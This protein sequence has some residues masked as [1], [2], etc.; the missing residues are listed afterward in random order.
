MFSN[1]GSKFSNFEILRLMTAFEKKLF[2]SIVASSSFVIW[3]I[4]SAADF[5][6][7]ETFKK[8]LADCN[9]LEFCN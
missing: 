3:V 8:L 2:S 5:R 9:F 4:S 6:P 1:K 7:N